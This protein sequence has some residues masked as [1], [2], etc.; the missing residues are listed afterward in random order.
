M[1]RRISALVLLLLAAAGTSYAYSA[2]VSIAELAAE[3][4]VVLLARVISIRESRTA[5]GPEKRATAEVLEVWKG[6]AGSRIEYIA[7]PGW[8]S[9]DTSHARAGETIALFLERDKDSGSYRIAHFGR[10]RMPVLAV[11]NERHASIYE[12]SFPKGVVV[13]QQAYP[14]LFTVPIQKLEAIVRAASAG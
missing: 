1:K 9:C 3:S 12:V 13:R 4:Q 2:L 5:L 14:F 10:G 7:S 11:G 8:F 6:T